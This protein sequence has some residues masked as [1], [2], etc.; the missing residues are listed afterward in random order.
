ML[1]EEDEDIVLMTCIEYGI[2]VTP[3]L[4]EK[5]RG[6]NCIASDVFDMFR[7]RFVA[8]GIKDFP[9]FQATMNRYRV[10]GT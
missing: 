7:E 5:I 6:M 1:R 10:W 9:T 4:R 8:V 2:P 3:K